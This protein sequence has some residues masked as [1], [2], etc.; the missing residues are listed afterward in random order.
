VANASLFDLLPD[1]ER[2]A[3]L[4]VAHR[5]RFHRRDT[6]FHEGDPGDSLHV[7]V[8]G[9]VA[10]RV[11]TPRGDVVTLTVHGRGETF[12]EL[13]AIHE[14][15]IRSASAVAVSD[16]ETLTISRDPLDELRERRPRVDRFIIDLLA[17]QL[18]RVNDH[19]LEALYVPADKRILRRLLVLRDVCG[20]DDRVALPFTQEDLA[21]MAGTTRPTVNRVLTRLRHDGLVELGRG[22]ITIVD[23]DALEHLAH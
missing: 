23:R 4:M 3:L 12:G 6:L 9:L 10:I 8:S 13:A 18:R 11:T 17:A 5:R 15:G 20:G 16:V 22:R 21:S 2:R 7:V 1:D 19:L 14:G